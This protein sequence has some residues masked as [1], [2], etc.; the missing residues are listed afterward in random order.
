M[1][2]V[3]DAAEFDTIPIKEDLTSDNKSDMEDD[4]CDLLKL[5]LD[6]AWL[7]SV[8]S[9]AN[10]F[11]LGHHAIFNVK[12]AHP[13]SPKKYLEETMKNYPSGTWITL[14]RQAEKKEVG[15]VSVGYKYNKK[16]VLTFVFNKAEKTVADKLYS[17]RFLDK[18]GNVCIR[19][20][21]RPEVISTYF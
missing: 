20:I 17:V 18:Y 8:K 1:R 15:L 5:F 16:N 9:T 19:Q 10:V 14:E 7:G 2:G 3:S 11:K 12:T 4:N 21:T 13:R 6:D